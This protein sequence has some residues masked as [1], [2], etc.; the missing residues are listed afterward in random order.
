ML[1]FHALLPDLSQF[2][3]MEK[4]SENRDMETDRFRDSIRA[5]LAHRGDDNAVKR[6]R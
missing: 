6:T 5:Y 2:G 4:E 1:L 3:E